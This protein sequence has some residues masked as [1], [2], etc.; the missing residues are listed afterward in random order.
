MIDR[1]ITRT[2]N[3]RGL[4]SYRASRH[5]SHAS[6][7]PQ[8]G[9]GRTRRALRCAS[10]A[11]FSTRSASA[12]TNSLPSSY[13]EQAG[14]G[15][16]DERTME[17]PPAADNPL[18]QEPAA[19]KAAP[20]RESNLL[21]AADIEAALEQGSMTAEGA[22][23]SVLKQMTQMEVQISR[24]Q[25]ADG[26]PS[27]GTLEGPVRSIL[28]SM[29]E[30]PPNFHQYVV[31]ECAGAAHTNGVESASQPKG[32]QWKLLLAFSMVLAQVAVLAG[33]KASTREPSCITSDQCETG[34]FCSIG[35]EN[36]C[37]VCGEVYLA[38]IQKSNVSVVDMCRQPNPALPLPYPDRCWLDVGD[39]R[40]DGPFLASWCE[41][42]VY[43]IDGA[44]RSLC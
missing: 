28:A 40:G 8:P 34:W 31:F 32:F 23:G 43:P 20:P 41:A 39:G 30:A 33:V 6:Y 44:V 18:W 17:S 11:R 37:F 36:R 42:C 26:R 9:V 19:S 13:I 25:S 21:S 35:G 24:M 16:A 27:S 14:F 5:P 15:R 22:I 1:S 10:R 3:W 4:L 7:G 29:A 12:Q 2:E 38:C